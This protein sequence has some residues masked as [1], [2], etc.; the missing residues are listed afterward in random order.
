MKR[1]KLKLFC[2]M[3]LQAMLSKTIAQNQPPVSLTLQEVIQ[4]TLQHHPQLKQGE[5]EVKLRYSEL[6]SSK[7]ER[8]PQANIQMTMGYQG[9]T[10]LFD[11]K[12][13]QE[14]TLKN[15][16][17]NQGIHLEINQTI[18]N[19]H[20]ITKTI[21]GHEL[22]LFLSQLDLAQQRLDLELMVSK[23][24]LNLYRV[25][26]LQSIYIKNKALAQDRLTLVQQ[27]LEQGMVTKEEV[28]LA[29]LQISDIELKQESNR[30]DL[31]ILQSELQLA[32]G[33]DS[34]KIKTNASS[35][36]FLQDFLKQENY[37][38]EEAHKKSLILKKDEQAVELQKLH[39][40]KEKSKRWPALY[41]FMQS[42]TDRPIRSTTPQLDLYANTW[43]VGVGIK[44]D[45]MTLYTAKKR[46]KT[47]QIQLN[48]AEEQQNYVIKK[49]NKDISQG[50]LQVRLHLSQQKQLQKA[51]EQA[52]ENY[53]IIQNKYKAQL[54]L[55][56]DVFN[57]SNILLETELKLAHTQAELL[58]STLYLSYLI[59]DLN[60]LN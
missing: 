55:Y 58:Y 8:L 6:E 35:I 48:I 42:A 28:L 26:L 56:L 10:T 12:L 36:P 23:Y 54:A 45:L 53:R 9:N 57:A 51:L 21:Q 39:L 60:L 43:Q 16:H 32:M 52:K 50:Y 29:E 15:L 34:I 1:I 44:Y 3:F 20:R 25:E 33:A 13:N 17:F 31:G 38:V 24:Y 19:G 14:G 18:F 37:Y 7:I 40:E 49:L 11:K 5:E 22:A 2:L 46:E 27:Y 41:G 30:T 4:A 47:Y 59:G